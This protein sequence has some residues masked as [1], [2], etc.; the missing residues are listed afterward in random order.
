MEAVDIRGGF[1]VQGAGAGGLKNAEICLVNAEHVS[2]HFLRR[3][4]FVRA[5]RGDPLDPAAQKRLD[6]VY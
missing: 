2:L 3:P 6:C 1:A 5:T 4:V